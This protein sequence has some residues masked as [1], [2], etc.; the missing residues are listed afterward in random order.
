[1]HAKLWSLMA[2][3]LQLIAASS[4]AAESGTA[5][6]AGAASVDITPDYPVRLSGYG[7]RTN[8]FE[9]V[10][11][12]IHAK[13]L[14]LAWQKDAPAVIVTVDNCGVPATLRADVLK[15]LA[16]AG[17]KIADAR[18]SLHSSHTHC[19]PML[20][21]V[22]P[23]IF[24]ADLSAGQQERVNRYTE[25][26]TV[27]L[28]RIVTIALD[29]IK[30]AHLDWSIGKVTF[31]GN[32]RLRTGTSFQNAPNPTG[33]VDHA[34]PVL[35][36][37][38]ADDKLMAVFTSYACHCTTLNFNEVHGDWAGCAR[39]EIESHFPGTVCLVALGCGGDQNPYPRQKIELVTQHG[40]ALA[41][42]VAR[43]V[44]QPMKPVHGPLRCAA[45]HIILPF[46]KLPTVEEWKAKTAD[47]SRYIAYHAR[48]FLAMAERGQKIPTAL[49]YSVQVWHY[50]DDLLTINLPGEVVVDYSLRFKREYD[51]ARTW[52]NGY[53]N[54]V[55]CYI[56]S[57]RVWEEGGYEAAGAMIYYAR[58][59]R[60]AS[61]VETIIAR[62]VKDLVPKKFVNTAATH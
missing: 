30:P 20:R 24:G 60:F 26:L 36:V 62:A 1:M 8:E 12:H 14:V 33:P 28:V 44:G 31:A 22:L 16:A 56:P 38:S 41:A 6:K 9:R 54:D 40:G 2:V 17:R 21:G 25:E 59:T 42:E 23:F 53:S 52:V 34:L 55:P 46:D 50:G 61:G 37:K 15:R 11:Q 48:Q 51:P 13:A 27:K 35:R 18:F 57:Q 5:W 3:S 7:S 32:R 58:P 4:L 47:K 29:G 45:K 19:A 39:E 43:V 49:P 10:N